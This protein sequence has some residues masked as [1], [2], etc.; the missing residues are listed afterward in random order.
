M[1]KIVKKF[2]LTG[3]KFI[4]KFRLKQR[5]RIQKFRET[6]NLKHS[7]RNKLDK[8]C[9]VHDETHSNSKDLAKRTTSDKVVSD[10]AYE[11]AR[12]RGYG[13]YERAL[14]STVY[15]FFN[16]K[17]GSGASLNEQLAKELHNSVIKN[18]KRRKIYAK[19]R[20]NIWA[21]DLAEMKSLPSKNKNV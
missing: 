14:T 4:Q 20:D 6:G 21:A 19:F 9:C 2:L 11:I 5:K 18:F 1:N 10:R 8:A 12:N 13:G 16:R 7:D 17:T 3:D 15:R